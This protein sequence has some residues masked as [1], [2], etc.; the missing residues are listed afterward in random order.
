MGTEVLKEQYNLLLQNQ[1]KKIKKIQDKKGSSVLTKIEIPNDD[2]EE[3][4]KATQ[5]E[6]DKLNQVEFDQDS[7]ED[8]LK[9][10]T[11]KRPNESKLLKEHESTSDSLSLID[12][13]RELK[14]E[15]G[16]IKKLLLE[17]DYEINYLKKKL[18][19]EKQAFNGLGMGSDAIALKI[20]D[21]SKKIRE[22]TAD[23]E[24]EKTK[25][26]KLVKLN[27]D[28][29]LKLKDTNKTQE[30]DN[31]DDDELD[32]T[33]EKKL[34]KENKELKEKLNQTSAK[35]MEFKSQAEIV[36]LDLKRAQNALEKEVGDNVD[37]KAILNGQ[38]NWK[39]RQQQIRTLKSKVNN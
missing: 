26:K 38:S 10:E 17:K 3:L 25:T 31:D 23:L 15:N 9:I 13:L 33:N 6:I 21:L 24:S 12:K 32:E 7:D 27:K 16:R 20:V 28:L 19:E 30:N 8:N 11:F 34:A 29:E 35:M 4:E 2:F 39:G 37:I 36:R 5:N 22:L 18:D 1:K 14:D